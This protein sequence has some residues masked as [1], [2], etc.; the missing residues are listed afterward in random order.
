MNTRHQARKPVNE[1]DYWGP[2][3]EMS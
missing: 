3:F 2:I 1:S